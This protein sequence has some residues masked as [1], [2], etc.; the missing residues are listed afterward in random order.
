MDSFQKMLAKWGYRPINDFGR[1]IESA[2]TPQNPA[3]DPAVIEA[4]RI[5]NSTANVNLNTFEVN[6][7]DQLA[8]DQAAVES[9]K[10]FKEEMARRAALH[11]FGSRRDAPQKQPDAA[12]KEIAEK[13][14]PDVK[15]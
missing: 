1:V 10:N 12:L 14:P 4:A 7:A 5:I 13:I 3:S 15:L 11:Q 9:S 6:E 2:P 8:G